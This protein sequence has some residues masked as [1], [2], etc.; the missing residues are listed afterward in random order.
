MMHSRRLILAVLISSWGLLET[1]ATAVET[2]DFDGDGQISIADAIYAVA[3]REPAPGSLAGFDAYACTSRWEFVH[4]YLGGIVYLEVLRRATAG[5][6]HWIPLWPETEP[7]PALPVD[8]GVRIAWDDTPAEALGDDGIELR[9]WLENDAPI[10][11]FSFVVESGSNVLR[12]APFFDDFTAPDDWLLLFSQ[13]VANTHDLGE[14]PVGVDYGPYLITGG[15]LVLNYG[16]DIESRE[17]ADIAPGRHSIRVRARLPR[18]STAG[19]YELRIHERSEVLLGT[20][21]VVASTIGPGAEFDLLDDVSSGWDEGLPPL[22]L[23]PATKSILGT[24]ELRVVGGEGFPGST[25][26]ARVEMRTEVPL[27]QLGYRVSW[28]NKR[29]ACGDLRPRVLFE[30]PEDGTPYTPYRS[31]PCTNGILG[32]GPFHEAEFVLKGAKPGGTAHTDRPLEYFKP[33]RQWITLTEFDLRIPEQ[34]GGGS[35]IPLTLSVPGASGLNRLGQPAPSF[36]PYGATWPCFPPEF[37]SPNWHYDVQLEHGAIRV[38]G[39][40]E[41]GEDPEP[42]EIGLRFEVGSVRAAPGSV[43][44]V[45]VFA[46]LADP[47]VS[48]LRLVLEV[49]PGAVTVESVDFEVLRLKDG[50]VVHE[51]LTRGDFRFIQECE[52]PGQLDT[53]TYGV[54]FSMVFHSTS[55]RYVIL[56]VTPSTPDATILDYPGEGLRHIATLRIRILEDFAGASTTVALSSAPPSETPFDLDAASGGFLPPPD[57]RFSPAAESAAAV[58][59][60]RGELFRRGDPNQDGGADLSDA[61]YALGYLFTGGATPP[62]IAEADFDDSGDVNITDPIYLLAHLFLGGPPPPPPY[63]ECGID[64]TEDELSC[65]APICHVP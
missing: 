34:A 1:S 32:N 39:N 4:Q 46:A 36:Q 12:L 19:R 49:D 53:C 30:D 11:A 47:P 35:E 55:E 18:G 6:P 50:E 44:E 8:P 33:L 29:L 41:P 10:R 51:T 52:E 38:L 31:P 13:S 57:G 62:C 20:G 16:L 22:E 21:A 26:T 54:P 5:L 64:P 14:I 42:P 23:D 28:P 40:Q 37:E 27:N 58:L 59:L 63:G 3:G 24:V 61:I 45:P 15:R 25:V 17:Q 65:E 48:L 43:V 56:D 2:G 60:V 9:L 7:P